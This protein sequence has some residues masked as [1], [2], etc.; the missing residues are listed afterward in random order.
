VSFTPAHQ[1]NSFQE[2]T[3]RLPCSVKM[4]FQIPATTDTLLT[5]P[6]G[7]LKRLNT[8]PAMGCTVWPVSVTSNPRGVM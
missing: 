3:V 7:S 4:S 5:G 8:R 2:P 1:S 6:L